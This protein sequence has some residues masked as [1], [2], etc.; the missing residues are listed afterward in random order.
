MHFYYDGQ[1]KPGL[2]TYNGSDYYYLYNLQGDV[3]G[4]VGPSN[5]LVVEYRYDPW[6]KQLACTGSMAATLGVDNP[7]RYRGYVFDEE[8]GLYA[9]PARFYHPEWRRFINADAILTKNLFAYCTNSPI[10]LSDKSGLYPTEATNHNEIIALEAKEKRQYA[11][12]KAG[13][14]PVWFNASLDV[15]VP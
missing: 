7:F 5:Q 9:L 15:P 4:L 1:G 3:V 6:G 14:E 12:S 2:V 13:I 8:T 10:N 11:K